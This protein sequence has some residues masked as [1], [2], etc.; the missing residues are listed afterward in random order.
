M[1]T[2]ASSS[3]SRVAP[4][5]AIALG[6]VALVLLGC[7]LVSDLQ[8]APV[9]VAP[10]A[11]PTEKQSA[12]TPESDAANGSGEQTSMTKLDVI[13]DEMARFIEAR[14]KEVRQA[15]M[16]DDG[17]KMT[18]L[19]EQIRLFWLDHCDVLPEQMEKLL[20]MVCD[21][22]SRDQAKRE[23][24]IREGVKWGVVPLYKIPGGVMIDPAPSFFELLRDL[25]MDII[26]TDFRMASDALKHG[27]NKVLD[28]IWPEYQPRW[29]D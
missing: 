3:R 6:V 2:H 26:T 27:M 25:V 21:M 23:A 28:E 17:E 20:C 16:A 18:S 5:V 22:L 8:T 14:L 13:K 7:Y 10:S 9:Q 15:K 12:L 1:K 29:R 4:K 11:A 19:C 24:A